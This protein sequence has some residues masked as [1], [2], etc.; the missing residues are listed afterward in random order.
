MVVYLARCTNNYIYF[1]FFAYLDCTLV[2]IEAVDSITALAAALL[3]TWPHVHKVVVAATGQV[4]S[5]RGPLQPTH[6]LRV[7]G[8]GEDVVVC[9]PYIMVVDVTRSG[10]T[11]KGKSQDG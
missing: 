2:L 4:S 7:S 10:A 8:Q 6:L 9:Y 11:G 1:F 3:H 5:I